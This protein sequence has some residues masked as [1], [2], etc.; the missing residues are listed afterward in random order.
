MRVGIIGSGAAGLYCAYLL[1]KQGVPCTLIEKQNR[2]GGNIYPIRVGNSWID[3]GF[4][5]F[6]K[7]FYPLVLKLFNELG[8]D[9]QKTDMSFGFDI[10]KNGERFCWGS[11]YNHFFQALKKN[12]ARRSLTFYLELIFFLI[13]SKFTE[14]TPRISGR[15]FDYFISPLAKTLWSLQNS[16][17]GDTELDFVFS[18]LRNHKMLNLIEG[19][20]WYTL[21]GSSKVYLDRLLKTLAKT[22]VVLECEVKKIRVTERGIKIYSNQHE[23]EFDRVIMC[24]DADILFE[25]LKESGIFKELPKKPTYS[26][27]SLVVHTSSEFLPPI[28]G[29]WNMI[30]QENCSY[31]TYD[32]KKLQGFDLLVTLNYPDKIHSEAF[33]CNLRHPI[34]NQDLFLWR[35]FLDANQGVNNLFYAGAYFGNCFHEDAFRS[36]LK[37]V[38][39]LMCS[40]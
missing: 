14:D 21:S 35:D 6:N 30:I 37:V 40:V 15:V 32:L 19:A 26:D 5:V 34:I 2:V 16:N 10:R 36:A 23:F 38:N 25:I 29:A 20:D 3:L 17:I 8:L 1:N 7:D 12:G 22:E 9:F 31:I 24:L 28:S 11:S 18:F 13:K 4:Q 27:T 33:R 39:R